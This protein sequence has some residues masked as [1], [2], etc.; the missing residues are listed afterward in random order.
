[1]GLMPEQLYSLTWH[2]YTLKHRGYLNKVEK[3]KEALRFAAWSIITPH[4]KKMPSLQRFW[5]LSIDHIE[6]P[7]ET[8]NKLKERLKAAGRKFNG[9]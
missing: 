7:E 5:P 1:M 3:E 8:A 6:T 4:V 2:Q 9:E